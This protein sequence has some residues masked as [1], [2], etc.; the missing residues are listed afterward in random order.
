MCEII[1]AIFIFAISN[2]RTFELGN[3]INNCG[4]YF[5]DSVYIPRNREN[6]NPVK[7]SRYTVVYL[8]KSIENS[9]PV[10][11]VCVN[12]YLLK[13]VHREFSATS[14]CMCQI[15]STYRSP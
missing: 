11:S 7:I 12:Y 6:K 3:R 1:F 10:P 9:E 14:K 2:E 5:R 15:L 13:E 4:F 8:E